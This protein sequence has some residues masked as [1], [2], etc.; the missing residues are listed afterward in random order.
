MPDLGRSYDVSALTTH[1]LERTRR[2]LA[3]SLALA[4]PGSPAGVPIA[5]QIGAIDAELT[6][7][8]RAGPE[9]SA[10]RS[11]DQA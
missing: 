6:R 2:Y 4:R 11:R 9:G 10:S 8:D 5:A 7:R 1:E 3:A